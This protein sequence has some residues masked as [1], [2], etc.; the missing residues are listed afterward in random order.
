MKPSFPEHDS[1]EEVVSIK[2]L[3]P[4]L[5]DVLLRLTDLL[6]DPPLA[7]LLT[8]LI[9]QE[10]IFRLLTGPHG[11][12]LRKVVAMETPTDQIARV[13]TWIKK[14]FTKTMRADELAVQANMSPSAFRSI[15]SPKAV[16]LAGGA[17]THAESEY[18]RRPG[19]K[20]RGLRERFAI[21][22]RI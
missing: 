19:S 9:E 10:I 21:Q 7:P 4:A 1:A 13:L 12:H 6:D 3:D 5:I 15:A 18:G 11:V 16:A 8:P 22:P 20:H 14:N 2:T 17:A